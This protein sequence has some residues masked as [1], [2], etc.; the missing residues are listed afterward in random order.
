MNASGESDNKR[1]GLSALGFS[2]FPA[3]KR[4]TIYKFVLAE[5]PSQP[6]FATKYPRVRVSYSANLITGA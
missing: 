6:N 1:R 3:V 4:R 2:A 5:L